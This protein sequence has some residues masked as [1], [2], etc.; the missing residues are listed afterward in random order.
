MTVRS[1]PDSG[2][3]SLPIGQASPDTRDPLP[4]D[5]GPNASMAESSWVTAWLKQAEEF[6]RSGRNAD[7]CE[8]LDRV[9]R[10]VLERPRL[11]E[12]WMS[13]LRVLDPGRAKEARGSL[14]A[15]VRNARPFL[16]TPP[17]SG[18]PPDSHREILSATLA[19]IYWNQGHQQKALEMY[20]ALLRR[21][22]DNPELTRELRDRLEEAEERLGGTASFLGVLERWAEA[23]RRRK[24][25]LDHP[26]DK[27][28]A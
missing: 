10:P 26:Q 7:A 16:R 4:A 6:F 3:S 17:E 24:R 12:I 27:R 8:M 5:V 28:R 25:S 2:H 13:L 15:W 11:L 9:L 20:R 22:P 19:R 23:V 21:Y 18:S 14:R 1:S